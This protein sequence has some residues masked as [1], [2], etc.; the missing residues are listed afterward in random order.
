MINVFKFPKVDEYYSTL[1]NPN[2]LQPNYDSSF[3]RSWILDLFKITSGLLQD[4]FPNSIEPQLNS[5]QLNFNSNSELGTTQLK[6]VLGYNGRVI[7]NWT[8][9]SVFFPFLIKT[10]FRFN[11]VSNVTYNLDTLEDEN[12]KLKIIT[13]MYPHPFIFFN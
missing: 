8:M 1:F 3:Y 9:F 5:T 4:Y 12:M 11:D 6:L 10:I 13:Q 2:H 7:I